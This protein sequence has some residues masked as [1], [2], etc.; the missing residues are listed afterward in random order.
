MKKI[1]LSLALVAGSFGI[2]AGAQAHTSVSIG[3]GLGGWGGYYAPPPVVYSAPPVVYAP[4]P[5][6]VY[7]YPAYS[8]YYYGYGPSVVIH[9]GYGGYY[10]HR[11]YRRY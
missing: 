11:Y 8:P 10:G 1:F 7:P 5:P 3:L 6:P 4:P 9:S 2:M